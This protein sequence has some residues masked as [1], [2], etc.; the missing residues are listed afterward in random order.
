MSDTY[1]G[2]SQFSIDDQ[3]RF[4]ELTGDFNPLHVDE[5]A[6]RRSI[7][8][9]ATVHGIHN[10]LSGLEYLAQSR[11]KLPSLESLAVEF[12]NP[13][14]VGEVVLWQVAGE[15][16]SNLKLKAFVRERV[17][18]QMRLELS[19]DCTD[20]RI[21]ETCSAETF[22]GIAARTPDDVDFSDMMG[23]ADVLRYAATTDQFAL[24][25]PHAS[26]CFGAG[27][28]RDLGAC[29]W[30]VGMQCPGLRSLFSR[31]KMRWSPDA[32][33]GS[34]AYKVTDADKRFSLVSMQIT[35]TGIIGSV[36]AFSPPSPP[37][38]PTISILRGCVQPRQFLGQRA[39]VVGGSRGLGELTA[40]TLAVGGAD[41]VIT[42]AKGKA[43]AIAVR[44]DIVA[45]GGSARILSYDV[46]QAANQLD[47]L[48][49]WIP[50]HVYYFA[51]GKI[52][53]TRGGG[54]DT[55]ILDRFKQW[56][57]TGFYELCSYL[58]GRSASKIH[59]FYPS[60][61]YVEERPPNMTE[62][63]MIKAAGEILCADIPSILPRINVSSARLPRLA[64]DQNINLGEDEFPDALDVLLPILTNASAID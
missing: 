52:G 6:A 36:D 28:L 30:L 37:A 62:Y 64:T 10:V 21:A 2:Q 31:L 55:A 33:D 48:Q 51:T 41:V 43:D 35:G 23:R 11:P 40:K 50:T 58:N 49:S 20:A 34:L 8:G 14:R 29:S 18:V 57:L 1:L 13:V 7:V 46:T 26:A 42:Y 17:V 59:V 22:D 5:I 38:M 24:A 45:G 39:L 3:F 12:Q 54:L 32:L 16:P 56:Y 9:A 4:A 27:R 15:G 61:V 19:S 25:F 44:D 47:E 63:A 60:T 53:Q